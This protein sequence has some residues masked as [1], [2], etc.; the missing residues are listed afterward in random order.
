VAGSSCVHGRVPPSVA[1]GNV[2]RYE[3]QLTHTAARP[4]FGQGSTA[5]PDVHFMPLVP[6][7]LSPVTSL[8]RAVSCGWRGVA[9]LFLAHTEVASNPLG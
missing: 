7:L 1:V 4:N 5:T 2:V 9:P 6:G 8:P 3:D